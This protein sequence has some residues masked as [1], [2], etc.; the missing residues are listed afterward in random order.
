MA[1]D[2]YTQDKISKILASQQQAVAGM[3]GATQQL[4]DYGIRGVQLWRMA[5]ALDPDDA[6]AA[7]EAFAV[8]A[9]AQWRAK[10]P[11]LVAGLDAV[12][13]ATGMTREQMAAE[14]VAAP[15]TS[16]G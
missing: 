8:E 1:V 15:A 14:I 3:A 13:A 10:L 12:S 2:F 4:G 5:A 11:S 6:I 9:Y 7:G 16:F